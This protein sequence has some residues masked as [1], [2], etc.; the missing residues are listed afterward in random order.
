MCVHA[1]VSVSVCVCLSFSHFVS[2]QQGRS[3]IPEGRDQDK[4]IYY[5]PCYHV[6]Q[7]ADPRPDVHVHNQRRPTT[8]I[9]W[10][11]WMKQ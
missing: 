5:T 10:M 11:S 3:R 8:N 1:C 2:A 7:V 9:N 6:Q 4:I